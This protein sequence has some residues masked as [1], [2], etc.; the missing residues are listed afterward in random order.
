MSEASA[1]GQG[2]D[3][4]KLAVEMVPTSKL[5]GA[6][7]NPRDND[8][9]V[10]PVEDSLR[11]FGWQQPIVARKDGTV[12]AGN[13]RLKAAKKLE[14]EEVPVVWFEGDETEAKAFAVADNR[15]HEFSKWDDM[16]LRDILEGLKT[17]DRYSGI[18][19]TSEQ[20]SKIVDGVAIRFKPESEEQQGDLD[21]QGEITCPKCNHV[22]T[23]D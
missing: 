12:I 19:Y 21:R 11:R 10:L 14:M 2:E 17:E 22:F 6:D 23:K 7:W 8:R 4:E 16:K 1:N 13:T 9:A 3:K 18:G 15:T 20:I 5:K